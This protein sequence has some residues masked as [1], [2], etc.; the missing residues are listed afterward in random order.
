MNSNHAALWDWFAQCAKITK[1]FFSFGECTDTATILVPAGETILQEFID[2]S[3]RVRY[4]FELIR[5]LPVSAQPNDP[6]NVEMMEDVEAIIDWVRRQNEAGD[7]PQIPDAAVEEIAAIEEN[8]GYVAA[9][10][11]DMAKYMIPFAMDYLKEKG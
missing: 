10:D 7:F 11:G 6:G 2:G 3:R 8:A 5:F 4:N 1:L 9:R